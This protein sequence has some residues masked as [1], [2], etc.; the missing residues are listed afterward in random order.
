MNGSGVHPLPPSGEHK[1]N[2]LILNVHTEMGGG[3][4]ALYYTLRSLDRTRIR[5]L[6]LFN[7]Q[8]AFP[9]R[10][11]DLGIETLIVPFPA[12]M[13]RELI[14]P[15]VLAGMFRAACRMHRLLRE[16]RID[17]VQCSDILTLLLVAFPVLVRRLPVIYCV[18]FFYEWTRMLLFNLLAALLVEKIVANS[19]AVA[20]DVEQKTM[21]LARRVEVIEPGVDVAEFRPRAPGERDT[22]RSELGLP[23]NVK[24]VGMAARFEPVKGH[25]TFLR[26]AARVAE[27]RQDVAFIVIG[28]AINEDIIPAL[29]PYRDGIVDECARLGLEGRVHFL[30]HR[31]DMPE[32]LRSLDVLAVPSEREGFGLVVPEAL[33]SGVPVIL[34]P[35]AG[36]WERVHAYPAV[37][38]ARAGDA[39]SFAQ[40]IVKVLAERPSAAPARDALAAGMTWNSP[41]ERFT[42]LYTTCGNPTIPPIP[43]HP[44]SERH[45][46]I[47]AN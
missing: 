38:T 24:L 33:A 16:E 42:V 37:F 22:L 45:D 9:D 23:E 35:T 8:G 34:P 6:M 30:G 43:Q 41:A 1:L 18:I 44:G 39:E 32:L 15:A 36:V 46:G 25:R 5:P 20:R 40:S 13:L 14:S 26:A 31:N 12:V 47:I 10:V 7:R 28:A 2:V 29:R 27:E 4:Y 21:M 11:R 3:E 17:V 19:H